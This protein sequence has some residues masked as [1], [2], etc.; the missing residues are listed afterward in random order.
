MDQQSFNG[1]GIGLPC[2]GILFRCGFLVEAQASKN[3]NAKQSKR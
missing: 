1:H 3:T 2:L